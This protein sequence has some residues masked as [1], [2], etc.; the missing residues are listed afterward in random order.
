MNWGGLARR[1]A[2]GIGMTFIAAMTVYLAA[3]LLFG[4]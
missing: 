4:S 1:T 3:R 2:T